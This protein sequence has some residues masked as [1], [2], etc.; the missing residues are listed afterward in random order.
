MIVH[1]DANPA[2]PRV[3]PANQLA[4]KCYAQDLHPKAP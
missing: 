2:K 3:E 1:L 4:T